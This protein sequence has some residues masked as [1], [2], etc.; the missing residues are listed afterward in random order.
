MMPSQ[1]EVIV[2]LLVRY[3]HTHLRGIAFVTNPSSF[4]IIGLTSASFFCPFAPLQL[5]STPLPILRPL[6]LPS[7]SPSST[8]WVFLTTCSAEIFHQNFGSQT[9][10]AFQLRRPLFPSSLT[11]KWPPR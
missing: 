1:K 2:S 5:T 7:R 8:F 4:P 3:V 6:L 11:A 10:V 9:P